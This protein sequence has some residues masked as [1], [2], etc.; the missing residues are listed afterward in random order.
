MLCGIVLV[1]THYIRGVRY[2]LILL[3]NFM[4]CLTNHLKCRWDIMRESIKYIHP[5]THPFN[6]STDP[7]PDTEPH[8]FLMS[9]AHHRRS[10]HE[11]RGGKFVYITFTGTLNHTYVTLLILGEETKL[12]NKVTPQARAI[13]HHLPGAPCPCHQQSASKNSQ[14]VPRCPFELYKTQLL[15]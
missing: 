8:N 15:K 3:N 14:G 11:A 4:L 1:Q 6:H 12:R 10:Q 7:S 9:T 5:P 13:S 2:A